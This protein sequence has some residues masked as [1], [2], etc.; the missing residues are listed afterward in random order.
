MEHRQRGTRQAPY[1]Y[2]PGSFVPLA[3]V[4]GADEEHST[5]W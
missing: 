5:Y 1:I 4:Q 3:T 2:E